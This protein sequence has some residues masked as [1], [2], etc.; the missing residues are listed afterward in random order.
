MN[1]K[2]YFDMMVDWKKLPSYKTEPRV[3]SLVGYFLRPLL[4][5]YLNENIVGIIPELPIRLGTVKPELDKKNYADRSYK[6]DFFAIG[7]N[8]INYL[9]EFKT[10]TSSRRANQDEYLISSKTLGTEPIIKGILKIADV[11]TYTKK[12]RHLKDKLKQ[13]RV[14]NEKFEYSGINQNLE[15]IYIQPSNYQNEK[16]VIDFNWVADWLEKKP[17]NSSYEIELAIALRKWSKD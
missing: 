10:D 2:E 9:V 4:S 5:E 7:E 14:L 13:Y 12:Y 1:W 15:I 11:S 8:G 16:S 17:N 3:D 6:V